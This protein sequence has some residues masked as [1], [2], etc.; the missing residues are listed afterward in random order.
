M[1]KTYF[2]MAQAFNYIGKFDEAI[3]TLEDGLKIKQDP[4]LLNLKKE[5]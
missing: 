4:E 1:V 2:R 3:K 5:V